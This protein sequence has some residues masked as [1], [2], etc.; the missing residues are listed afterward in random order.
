MNLATSLTA[1]AILGMLSIST[2]ARADCPN[3]LP[4]NPDEKQLRGC[5]EEIAV[6]RTEIT[7]L[8]NASGQGIV[9]GAVMA[10][11]LKLC[12]AGWVDFPNAMSRTIIGATPEGWE[13]G[14][15]ADQDNQALTPRKTGSKGGREQFKLVAENIPTLISQ[16][17]RM[18]LVNPSS[19]PFVVFLL[20]DAASEHT[21]PGNITIPNPKLDFVMNMPPYISLLYCK[22][23]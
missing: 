19:G 16:E 2:A 20:R 3:Q 5:L 7:R 22:K 15:Q 10:F 9:P 6:L 13:P 1:A 4:S 8:K 14:P 11:D 17:L 18:G 23:L 21:G 12:P